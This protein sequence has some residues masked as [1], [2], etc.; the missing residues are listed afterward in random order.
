MEDFEDYALSLDAEPL[1]FGTQVFCLKWSADMVD[2]EIRNKVQERRAE[3]DAAREVFFN[4][5]DYGCKILNLILRTWLHAG[6]D[7]EFSYGHIKTCTF[8]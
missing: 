6:F 8:W 2:E 4:E 1:L 7:D 3:L 5:E